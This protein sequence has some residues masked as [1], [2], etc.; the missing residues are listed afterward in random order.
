MHRYCPSPAHM[1][2]GRS[3]AALA[4]AMPWVLSV[5]C[6][7]VL[8]RSARA[9]VTRGHAEIPLFQSSMG[10]AAVTPGGAH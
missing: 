1:Q 3:G 6:D 2:E 8:I 10:K 7:S 9:P 5:C 4:G